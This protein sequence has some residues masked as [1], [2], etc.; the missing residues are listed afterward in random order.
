MEKQAR[1]NHPMS[2][3]GRYRERPTPPVQGREPAG[4]PNRRDEHAR[5]RA[6]GALTLTVINGESSGERIRIGETPVLVGRGTGVDLPIKDPTVSR[7]HCVVWSASGHCWVR[8]LGSTNRTRVNDR[9]IPMAEIFD[10]DVLMVGQTVLAL[11]AESVRSIDAASI[12]DSDR[13]R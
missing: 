9:A 12:A 4:A 1:E 13:A 3:E 6:N 2:S 8:D 5:R 10:G 7:H 11:S